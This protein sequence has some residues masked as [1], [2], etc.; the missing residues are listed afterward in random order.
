MNLEYA[1]AIAMTVS[2]VPYGKV[3]TYGQIARMS[4]L[5]GYARYVSRVLGKYS[6]EWNLPWHRVI[7]SDGKIAL[8]APGLQ[9]QTQLLRDEKIDVVNGSVNLKKFQW[10]GD[11]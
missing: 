7:R 8:R 2:Q 4:G 3:A 10:N 9:T 6:R 1:E 11:E 5:P